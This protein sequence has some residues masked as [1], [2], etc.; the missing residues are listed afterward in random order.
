MIPM[1]HKIAKI[2]NPIPIIKFLLFNPFINFSPVKIV[3]FN[4]NSIEIVYH[5]FG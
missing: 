1:M 2:K 5:E 3:D 4:I